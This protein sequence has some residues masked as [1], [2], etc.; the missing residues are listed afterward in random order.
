MCSA[1]ERRLRAQAWF[2]MVLACGICVLW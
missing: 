1:R 2:W